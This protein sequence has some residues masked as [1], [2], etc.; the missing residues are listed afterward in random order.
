M[1]YYFAIHPEQ[2]KSLSS[3]PWISPIGPDKSANYHS[4][5]L[6]RTFGDRPMRTVLE[7]RPIHTK[8][9]MVGTTFYNVPKQQSQVYYG[10]GIDAQIM[11]KKDGT[12]ADLNAKLVVANISKGEFQERLKQ[13]DLE[14]NMYYNRHGYNGTIDRKMQYE[15]DKSFQRHGHRP[16]LEANVGWKHSG[17]I[18]NIGG[19]QVSRATTF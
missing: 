7:E 15:Q 2:E 3:K 5:H 1:S 9:N 16:D 12:P 14:A 13:L 19:L 11:A 17:Y 18:P 10:P 8:R 6:E 4:Y